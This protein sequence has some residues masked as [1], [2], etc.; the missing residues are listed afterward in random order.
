MTISHVNSAAAAPT[1]PTIPAGLTTN[2]AYVAPSA[3]SSSSTGTS[4]SGGVS[5]GGTDFLTLMLAQL[6][7][8]D[9]TSPVDSNVFLTQLAELSTVQGITQLNTSF[10]TLSSSLAANQAMQASSLLGHQALVTS[11]SAQLAAG[12]T[13]SGVVN[14]PQTTSAVVLNIADSSGN[15]VRSIGLGAQAAGTAG[16]S[17][18]GKQANGSLAPAGNYTFS[19]QYAGQTSSSAA[20][21]T[22]INGTVE[23]V[24]MGAGSTGMTLNVAGVGSVPFSSLQQISN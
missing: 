14:V 5:L 12:G 18:D 9:P 1:T 21:T 13:V 19:V 8:Q 11:S 7:N 6:K 2:P 10:S 4:A 3:N 24:S 15:V 23:S 17:W 20:A 22:A 16:F